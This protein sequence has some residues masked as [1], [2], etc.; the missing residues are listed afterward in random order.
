MTVWPHM[1]T[2]GEAFPSFVSFRV[3]VL[4]TT[5]CQD[6]RWG[7]LG[8]LATGHQWTSSLLSL[9][10]ILLKCPIGTMIVTSAPVCNK[11]YVDNH[12]P[13]NT[14]WNKYGTYLNI[15]VEWLH[16]PLIWHLLCCRRRCNWHLS[17][18]SSA[19]NN[20]LKLLFYR[21]R[22]PK[23]LTEVSSCK[24]LVSSELQN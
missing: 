16:L 20:W 13:Y 17:Q 18:G 8:F 1:W 10:E 14:I 22:G 11:K 7:N 2:P 24:Y 4:R 23:N 5:R 9:L 21:F 6:W 15:A 3:A 12:F 19:L